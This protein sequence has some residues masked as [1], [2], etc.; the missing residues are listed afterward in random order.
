M[1]K[2]PRRFDGEDIRWCVLAELLGIGLALLGKQFV[3]DEEE[4][5]VLLI[6]RFAVIVQEL[7]YA[8]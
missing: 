1:S 8:G 7:R 6:Q 3:I 4:G 2:Y 5:H